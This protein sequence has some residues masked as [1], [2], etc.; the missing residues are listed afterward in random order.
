MNKEKKTIKAF[1]NAEKISLIVLDELKVRDFR[2]FKFGQRVV[3]NTLNHLVNYG[4]INAKDMYE[5]KI[6]LINF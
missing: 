5:W 2:D 4:L 1:N 3:F 6:N